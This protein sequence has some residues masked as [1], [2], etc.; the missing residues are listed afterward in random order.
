MLDVFGYRI[1]Y[2]NNIHLLTWFE[3]TF[4]L[5]KL[6]PEIA[7]PKEI[8]WLEGF[9]ICIL[10]NVLIYFL[11][12]LSHSGDLLLWVGVRRRPSFDVPRALTFSSQELLDQS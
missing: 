10:P 3:C 9:A 12:H 1:I 7:R 4:L 11:G 8:V 6:L 2:K 5:A